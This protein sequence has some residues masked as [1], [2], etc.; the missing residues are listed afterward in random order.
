MP[1]EGK[2]KMQSKG[3]VT[4][5]QDFRE[6]NGVEKGD[7]IYYKRHSRDNSKIIISSK[8]LEVTKK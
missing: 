6:E 2:R 8:P 3:Q 4:L 7:H 1:D 5:P